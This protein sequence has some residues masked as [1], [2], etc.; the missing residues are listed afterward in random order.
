MSD[1]ALHRISV[2]S[3][4][5]EFLAS[6]GE[7]GSGEGQLDRPSGIAFD[8]DEN[9]YVSDTLN[10]RVQKF[11]GGRRV[12]PAYVG[13]PR[14]TARGEFDMPW[15]ITVDELGV[16]LRGGL[17]KRQGPEVQQAT[18]SSWPRSS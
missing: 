10:H 8:A 1:E 4:D 16:R 15:G 11:S 2:F 14:L 7:H 17:A 9:V 5:R 3:K 18:A 12:L 6:W 13:L